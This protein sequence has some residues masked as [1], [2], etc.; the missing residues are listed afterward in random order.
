VQDV[1]IKSGDNKDLLNPFMRSS[2][3]EGAAAKGDLGHA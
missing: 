3:A 2:R 1:T